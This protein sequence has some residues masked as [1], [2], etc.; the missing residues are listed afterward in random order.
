MNEF[1]WQVEIA[2]VRVG[3]TCTAL[4]QGKSKQ[5]IGIF[6]LDLPPNI[7]VTAVFRCGIASRAIIS[8]RECAGCM[9]VSEWSYIQVSTHRCEVVT[10]VTV[11]YAH[12]DNTLGLYAPCLRFFSHRTQLSVSH[13]NERNKFDPIHNFP[14]PRHVVEQKWWRKNIKIVV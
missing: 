6:D 5:V 3:G 14:F 12:S 11:C 2:C 9:P 13:T 1:N 7:L 4:S 10:I 8:C